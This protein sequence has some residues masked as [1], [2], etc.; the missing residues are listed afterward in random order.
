M[1]GHSKLHSPS[2]SSRW[3]ACPGSAKLCAEVPDTSSEAARL[4]TAAHSVGEQCLLGAK[5]TEAFLGHTITVEGQGYKVDQR[6]AEGVQLYLDW[7]RRVAQNLGTTGL[8]VEVDM[9]LDRIHPDITGT[10]D[11]LFLS[12][13][14]S[15][16]VVV[17][18]KNGV[19]PKEAEGSSQLQMYALMALDQ[20]MCSKVQDVAMVI[21]QPW[22]RA[23]S[24]KRV[25]VADRTVDQLRTWEEVVLVP[26]VTATLQDNAP[27]V[28]GGDE[29]G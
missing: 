13:D 2:A 1:A 14:G 29:L 5:N 6:M 11:C 4:G 24:I 22:T 17:D 9:N 23:G 15:K 16:L 19:G 7:V 3:I 10:S 20:P 21:I 25:Q 8:Y 18:Y 12:A 28:P 27:I 26:A